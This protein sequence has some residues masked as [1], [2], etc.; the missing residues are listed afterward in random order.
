MTEILV[1]AVL[2]VAILMVVLQIITLRRGVTV[3]LT[4]LQQALQSVERCYERIERSVREEIAKNRE[5][6]LKEGRQSREELGSTLKTVGEMTNQQLNGMRETVEQRLTHIQQESDKKLDAVRQDSQNAAKVL[7]EEIGITLKTFNDS[8]IASV[9]E[10]GKLQKTHLDVFSERLDKLTQSNDQRLG[11]M[12]ETIEQRLTAIQEETGKKL[13]QIRMESNAAAQKAREEVTLSLGTFRE[14]LVATLCQMGAN[15]RE[16]LVGVVDQLSKLTEATEKK[17][18]A[19]KSGVEDKLK[20]LQED[21]GKQLELMRSTVDEKLQG[22]LEKRL[23]ESFKLVGDRLEQVHKGLGEMQVLATGV[24]DL[25]KVLTNVKTRGTWGEVQLGAL[26]EQVLNPDQYESNVATK[27]D[28][29][30]VEYAIKMQGRGEGEDAVLWL[31]I[32]AKFPMEDYQR[33]VEAQEKG[34]PGAAEA[35]ANQLETRVKQ[36]ARD[37]CDKY[38]NPPQTTD[39]AILFLPTE[40]LFAEVLR[41]IG[42]DRIYCRNNCRVAIA[43]PYDPLVSPE[44]SANGI[45]DAGHSEAIQRGLE[46]SCGGQIRVDQIRRGIGQGSEE[47]SRSIQYR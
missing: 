3:D 31:P 19:L 29:S 18:D 15:Q 44:Q 36:C 40:G 4:P 14:S 32:D 41:R 39:F 27:D 8:L 5:E 37:I 28:R 6:G 38:I 30:R 47:A 34:D 11:T 26:L 21:N 10:M 1:V 12:R 33:L 13:D 20:S 25:K 42:P 45:Q 35:A 43:R 17:L 9:G 2:V 23:G 7:R 24:G 16:Q 22:T 46:A